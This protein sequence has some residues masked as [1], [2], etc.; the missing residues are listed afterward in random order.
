MNFFVSPSP[1][2][3]CSQIWGFCSE[4]LMDSMDF[5]HLWYFVGQLS[6]TYPF[7][8][9]FDIVKVKWQDYSFITHGIISSLLIVWLCVNATFSPFLRVSSEWDISLSHQ[10]CGHWLLFLTV[11]CTI[12]F[13]P[14][15]C[16]KKNVLLKTML[17]MP[18][19]YSCWSGRKWQR[20]AAGSLWWTHALWMFQVYYA[21]LYLV[22]GLLLIFNWLHW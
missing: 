19:K 7:S 11:S 6:V 20:S 10:C 21:Y 16:I 3:V 1:P 14:C 2:L 17:K 18:K 8:F 13:L 12:M 22:K 5:L 9:E 4:G 15:S